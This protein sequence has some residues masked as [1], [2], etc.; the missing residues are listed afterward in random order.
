MNDYLWDRGGDADEETRRLEELLG[1]FRSPGPSPRFAG[2]RWRAAPG[3]GRLS[4]L[5]F[6]L[7]IAAMLILGIALPTF[8]AYRAS[9]WAGAIAV[10]RVG[11]V[12]RATAPLRI[13]T[14]SIGVVDVAAGTTLRIVEKRRLALDVGTIHARTT[15]PPG[16]FIVDTPRAQAIDLGCEYVLDV[17]KDGSGTLRV[18][19][20]WVEL[21]RG[22][23]QSLVPRGAS[24]TFDAAGNLTAPVF[25]DASAEFKEA[26][27]RHDIAR[28]VALARTR[29]AFTLL[30]LFRRTTEEERLIVY[31]RLAQLVPPPPSITRDSMRWWTPGVT[32]DWWAPVMKASGVDAIK[33]KKTN[34]GS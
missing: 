10:Y 3:E 32:G 8:L 31:D 16:I 15:S 14:P 27:R 7:P 2:R 1:A 29:D 11:D 12:I 26:L 19:E 9:S 20:G 4:R 13:E 5:L 18:T 34:P 21:A 22:W 23:T 6:V 30:N 24:A 28:V 17:A 33:K 25:D